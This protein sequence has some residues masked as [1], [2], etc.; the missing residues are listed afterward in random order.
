MAELLNTMKLRRNPRKANKISAVLILFL[1]IFS[2]VTTN[3]VLSLS[4]LEPIPSPKFRVPPSGE[5][6]DEI[7][8]NGINIKREKIQNFS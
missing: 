2:Y 4:L 8:K 6:I 3:L 7:L 1:L 5:R